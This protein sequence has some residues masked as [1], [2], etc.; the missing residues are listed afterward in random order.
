MGVVGID[1]ARRLVGLCRDA[2]IS[3]FDTANSYAN[4]DSE[5]ILGEALKPYRKDIVLGSKTTMSMGPGHFDRGASR[6]QIVQ[7]C[8]DSLRRLGT[9]WIDIYQLHYPDYLVPVEETLRAL[10]D[11]IR[12]GKVR[13]IGCSNFS[14]WHMMKAMAASDALGLER[15]VSHQIAYSLIDRDPEI[16]LIPA[17]LDQG[18]GVMVWSPLSG[19]FLSGKY[20][21]GEPLPPGSRFEALP[22]Y[23]PLA[24]PELAYNVIDVLR[25]IAEK[26]GK[27]VGEVALNW[28]LRR[29]WVDTVILGARTEEQLLANLKAIEWVL[30][31]DD[32]AALET[33]SRTPLPYPYR[34]QRMI[35]GDRTPPVPAYRP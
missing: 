5:T 12:A 14:G 25:N 16:E 15:F 22:N 9:D 1:E 19:G 4:G 29:P 32:F 3:S 28:V 34:I 26:R 27:T 30:D 11:L 8:E 23:P 35:N 21:R 33:A 20:R 6:R 2:G 24:S 7:S 31:E 10:D 17:A 13:Y 18:V